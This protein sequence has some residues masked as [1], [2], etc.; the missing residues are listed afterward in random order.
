MPEDFNEQI[1]NEEQPAIETGGEDSAWKETFKSE[2]DMWDSYKHLQSSMGRKVSELT[3]TLEE[4]DAAINDLTSKF[5]SLQEKVS[6]FTELIQKIGTSKNSDELE[7]RRA[8]LAEKI[9]TEP[10][11]GIKEVLKEYIPEFVEQYVKPLETKIQTLEGKSNA[12]DVDGFREYLVGT[13]GEQVIADTIEQLREEAKQ[14]GENAEAFL[15]QFDNPTALEHA[16]KARANELYATALREAVENNDRETL[17]TLL[18]KRNEV[19]IDNAQSYGNVRQG[20]TLIDRVE[21]EMDK[22]Y[23]DGGL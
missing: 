16:I 17:S 21:A 5:E 11:E 7:R 2:D 14:Y 10:D 8:E 3:N 13:Y 12:E 15:L 18:Q 19:P 20:N 22:A 1:S 6:P 9:L 23:E 4:K